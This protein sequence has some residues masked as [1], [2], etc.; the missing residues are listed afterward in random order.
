MLNNDGVRKT[1]FGGPVQ[2]LA[3]VELQSSVGVIVN[4]EDYVTE[5][6]RKL[7]KAGTPLTGDLK[8]RAAAFSKSNNTSVKGAFTLQ[9]TTTFVADEVLTIDGVA[10]TCKDAE[11][12]ENKQ[13]AGA[14]AAAQVA[15]LLKMVK[16]AKYDVE[17]DEATDK[18]KFVQKTVDASDT[19]GP[20][21]SKTA[22]TGAIGSVTKTVD[23]V[24]GTDNSVGV[25]LH[26]VDVTSGNAN[27]TLL[28]F[29]FVDLNKFDAE[30]ASLITSEVED[31]L[32][33]KVTFIK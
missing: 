16:T 31:A 10:Y 4:G 13:F 6:T 18:I 30:T 28:I 5:G 1:T 12:V 8:N 7:V 24:A 2:I 17:A 3:N 23:P 21:V 20:T 19:T 22:T 29:G 26:D 32:K 14:N 25:L 33:G 9:I 11:D 15:S 27:G